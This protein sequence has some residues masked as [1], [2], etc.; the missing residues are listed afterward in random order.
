[1][2]RWERAETEPE[3]WHR[4]HL[5]AALK[6]SVEDL[7]ALLAD[8]GEAP[9]R[10]PERLDYVLRHPSK[11]DLVSVAY[12]REQVRSLDERYDHVASALLLAETGQV[13]GQAVFLRGHA[14]AGR[15]QRELAAAIA[16][17]AI[18]M[19]QLVWDASQRRDSVGSNAYFDQAVSAAQHIRDVVTEA[20][21]VLRK[22]YVAL[23]G[24]RNPVAGLALASRAAAISAADSN[25]IAGMGRLHVGEAFAMLDDANGCTLALRAAEEHVARIGTDDPAGLLFCP[26]A[27]AVAPRT[28]RPGGHRSFADPH[29]CS[30][31]ANHD[32]PRHQ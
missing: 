10:P 31:G 23:Y 4:P 19:G 16:E 7:A 20:H 21:A 3:P 32:G 30:V 1:M 12:L 9:S 14:T 5:A 27:A 24:I 11:V 25:V 28:G 18:L 29:D 17:S 8:V 15:V 13:H 22:S 2:V 26:R 6:L